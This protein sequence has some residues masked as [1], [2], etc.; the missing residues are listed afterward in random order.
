MWT[1]EQKELIIMIFILVHFNTQMYKLG[2]MVVLGSKLSL[3]LNLFPHFSSGSGLYEGLEKLQIFHARQR[4]TCVFETEN[5]T[6]NLMPRQMTVFGH[7]L[8]SSVEMT[9]IRAPTALHYY[10]LPIDQVVWVYADIAV[11][12]VLT[13]DHIGSSIS[14]QSQTFRNSF[15][16]SCSFDDNVSKSTFSQVGYH[17]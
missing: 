9:E 12:S 13:H 10:M 17:S 11:I 15:W 5:S 4:F 6:H 16:P 14:T 2:F 8:N 7:E 1:V 3:V